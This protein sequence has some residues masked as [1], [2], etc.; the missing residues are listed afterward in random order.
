MISS[1]NNGDGDGEEDDDSENKYHRVFDYCFSDLPKVCVFLHLRFNFSICVSVCVY[2][3]SK[4]I[5]RES[6][7]VA[8]LCLAL[9]CA[10]DF[11]PFSDIFSSIFLCCLDLYSVA[12]FS[13]RVASICQVMLSPNGSEHVLSSCG[14]EN[15]AKEHLE[16][17]HCIDEAN[18]HDDNSLDR[19]NGR[20]RFSDFHGFLWLLP[21]AV[22]SFPQGCN[23]RSREG[24][25]AI[26]IAGG[27]F[28]TH[29]LN[30]L[31]AEASLDM[32]ESALIFSP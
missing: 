14:E 7:D 21:S 3:Y 10:Y 8:S 2:F 20:M 31:V 5:S 13:L 22:F 23:L 17:G 9:N 25:L 16:L 29:V 19:R 11:H 6:G 28:T 4:S 32:E 27:N 18:M 1:D 15:G 26:D 24:Q 30:I 12:G